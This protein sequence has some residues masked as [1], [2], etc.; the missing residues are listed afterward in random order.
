MSNFILGMCIGMAMPKK[1]SKS[2]NYTYTPKY[3]SFYRKYN[4]IKDDCGISRKSGFIFAQIL[5]TMV[6]TWLFYIIYK[7]NVIDIIG[8]WIFISLIA[9]VFIVFNIISILMYKGKVQL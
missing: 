7:D 2:N 8:K 5:I 1:K 4:N 9:I 6:S 3:S